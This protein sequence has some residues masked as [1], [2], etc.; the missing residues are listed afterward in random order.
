MVREITLIGCSVELISARGGKWDIF[1]MTSDYISESDVEM[2]G[3]HCFITTVVCLS[4]VLNIAV[5]G[6]PTPDGDMFPLT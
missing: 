5:S 3:K 1:S 4:A 6:R 2:T